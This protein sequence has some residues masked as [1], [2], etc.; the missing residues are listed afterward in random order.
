LCWRSRFWHR[1]IRSSASL[2]VKIRL[3][4]IDTPEKSQA[5]GERSRQSLS[6]LCFGKDASYTPQE[7]KRYDRTVA[8]V[9]CDG[10]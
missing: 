6:D 9:A 5:F 4:N 1:R 10:T 2:T 8:V 7:V 3:A